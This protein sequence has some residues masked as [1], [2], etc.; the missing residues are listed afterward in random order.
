MGSS[1]T[2]SYLLCVVLPA[3]MNTPGGWVGG[4]VMWLEFLGREAYFN[5]H[6]LREQWKRDKL[7]EGVK[8]F[9][10]AGLTPGGLSGAQGSL[11]PQLVELC[12]GFGLVLFCSPSAFA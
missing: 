2:L 9:C 6:F 12:Q 3:W 8:Q 10:R 1:L 11:F 7:E 4:E 5:V